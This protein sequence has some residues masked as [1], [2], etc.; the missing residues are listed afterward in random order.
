MRSGSQVGQDDAVTELSKQAGLEAI[1]QMATAARARQL[2]RFVAELFRQH[3]FEVMVDPG[4]SR[5]RQTDVLAA[6]GPERY[7]IECKWRS[8]KANID[9]VDSLRSRLRRTTAH[10]VGILLSMSGFSGSVVSDVAQ[11]RHQPVLLVSGEELH[12]LVARDRSLPDLLWRKSTALLNDGRVLLDEPHRKRSSRKRAVVP[13]SESYFIFG[14]RQPSQ[15]LEGGGEIGS[16]FL[17][18]HRLEDIDWTPAAGLGVALDVSPSILD[19]RGLLDLIEKWPTWDGQPQTRAGASSKRRRTGMV[20][21]AR[22]SSTNCPAGGIERCPPAHDT[23]QVC[24][25]D[26]CD[27]G[28]TR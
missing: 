3:H 12:S 13:R 6:R 21:D 2:V 8:S 23:E 10:T 26:R 22:P 16:Q 4:V 27:N 20:S 5:P 1:G 18:T 25:L 19:Q 14:D 17:F 9:D 7:L 15:I 28:S 11:N 24:Y